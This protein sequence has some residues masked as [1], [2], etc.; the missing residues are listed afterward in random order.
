MTDASPGPD[1]AFYRGLAMGI[2]I[3]GMLWGL[4]IWLVVRHFST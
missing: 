4:I 1:P 2:C 3:C